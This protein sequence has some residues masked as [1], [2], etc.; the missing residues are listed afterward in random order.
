SISGE[1]G[2]GLARSW[3]NERLFGARLY[4]AF[5]DLKSAF[6]PNNVFN[7]G[8]I[9][10]APAPTE[11]LRLGEFYQDNKIET[12][13]DFSAEGGFN[14]AV[15][16]CNG[17]GQCRKLDVGVMC[18]SYHATK[19][20]RHSTRG[21]ANALRGVISGK[22][23]RKEF[24]GRAMYDVMDLCLECKACRTECPSNV[25]MAKMK[26]EFLYHYNK[27]HG[28][29]WRSRLFGG[30]DGLNRLGVAAWPLSNLL[31]ARPLNKLIQPCLGI[32]PQR[33]LPSFARKRF[34]RWFAARKKKEAAAAGASPK[35]PQVVLFHDTF[36]EYNH[37]EIGRA[38]VEIL[39]KTGHEVVLVERKCCGRPAISKGMLDEAR[40]NALHNVELLK[41][42]AARG[43]PIVGVEPS[44]L[45]TIREEYP[46]LIPGEETSRVAAQAVT[47]DEFLAGL[48][49]RGLLA[50]AEPK[51]GRPRRQYLLHGHCHQK[52]LV[53]TA[54]TLKVLNSLPG[55]EAHEIDAGCCGMA[56]SFGYEREHYAIS[57]AIGEQRLFPAVRGAAKETVIVADGISCREQIAHG[58]K[59]KAKHLVEVVAEAM[60]G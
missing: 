1:H 23:P 30:I 49:E 4:A 38:T 19:N 40:K 7:P 24:A 13:L 25:D 26:Y 5:Q 57:M 51:N 10:N 17:N 29:P 33:K 44:C 59:R 32:A 35:R 11:N 36:M 58:T 45:L 6:D 22:L 41:G 3:L 43:I 8:K 48:L 2:D 14:F 12:V 53:G 42:Y 47:I 39:E 55:A 52:A 20:D 54:P 46:S 21:R 16:M 56:G 27:A 37:P 50:F 31:G 15:E 9:V 18:P 60:E 34:S 28:V